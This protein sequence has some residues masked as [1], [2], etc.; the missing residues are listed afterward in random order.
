MAVVLLTSVRSVS[1]EE[2]RFPERSVPGAD[3]RYIH[4]IP[5]LTLSGSPEDMGSQQ[6]TL[7]VDPAKEAYTFPRQLLKRMGVG[8]TGWFIVKSASKTVLL[9]GL[10]RHRAELNQILAKTLVDPDSV[11]VSNAFLEI[12]RLGGCSALIVEDA[13]TN[14]DG[15]LFGRNFDF[16]SLG[17]LQKFSL[18]TAYQLKDRHSFVSIGFPGLVGVIS[19]M[20]DKGLAI[21]TLD[22]YQSKDGSAKFNPKGVPLTWTYRRILEECETVDEAFALL[23]QIPRTTWMNLAVCDKQRGAVFELTPNTVVMRRP[24][25]SIVSCTNHF[26]MPELSVSKGGHRFQAL[27]A[28]RGMPKVGL[29]EMSER[30]HA[31]HQSSWTIQTMIFE[32]KSGRIHIALGDGPTSSKPLKVL[33]VNQLLRPRLASK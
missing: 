24:T 30:L 2:F 33:D 1:A 10:Q 21:A 22:V 3:L 29:K 7:A 16:P 9:N 27:E 13:R 19:G 25:D 5:V 14:I 26:R 8:D 17:L 18:V 23:K 20:N 11:T 12:R 4:G 28:S 15:P 6:T 32:P 31:T